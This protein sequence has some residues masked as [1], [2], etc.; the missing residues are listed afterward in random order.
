ML[1]EGRRTSHRLAGVVDD[2]VEAWPGRAAGGGTAPPRSACAAGRARRSRVGRAHSSK[3]ASWLYRRAAS[4][5]NRVVTMSEAPARRSLMPG[6][7]ADLHAPAGEQRDPAAEIGRLGALGEVDRRRRPGTAGRRSGGSRRTSACRR[8][9]AA[10]RRCAAARPGPRPRS[11]G[12]KTLGVMNTGLPRRRRIPVSVSTSSSRCTLAT[13]S[14]RRRALV[15][16]RRASTSGSKALAA[17]LRNRM[18]SSGVRASRIERSA[19]TASSSSAAASSWS[20]R[21]D[22]SPT[23]RACQPGRAGDEPRRGDQAGSGAGR[24]G[25]GRSR[26]G[27]A[28]RRSRAGHGPGPWPPCRAW[29]AARS[30]SVRSLDHVESARPMLTENSGMRAVPDGLQRGAPGCGAA[31]ARP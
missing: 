25:R 3:S 2:V 5:G 22:S 6:L 19:L 26:R 23:P 4:R 30:T 27:W 13:F 12:G 17:A 15:W 24:A 18:R 31:P 11:S 10:R 8:S 20:V 16:R 1:V 28:G 29:S 9:S 14:C 7:V 21:S